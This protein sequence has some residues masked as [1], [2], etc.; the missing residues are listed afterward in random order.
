MVILGPLAKLGITEA[1]AP[2]L[3][4][5]DTR[6]ATVEPAVWLLLL[7]A[8]KSHNVHFVIFN[9]LLTRVRSKRNEIVKAE[10]SRHRPN[11]KIRMLSH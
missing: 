2:K 7:L 1:E 5:L 10:H 11:M 4:T 9:I 8:L 3:V 6:L